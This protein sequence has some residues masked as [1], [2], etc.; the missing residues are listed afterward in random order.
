MPARKTILTQ[1]TQLP[2]TL[3]RREQEALE[4]APSYWSREKFEERFIKNTLSQILLLDD[5][6]K[7]IGRDPKTFADLKEVLK[8]DS[9]RGS[10]K[11]IEDWNEFLT[12]KV[13]TFSRLLGLKRKAKKQEEQY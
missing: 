1:L 8:K 5:A 7:L 9:E 3:P 6:P 12:E 11:A 13:N 4:E 10:G 2:G